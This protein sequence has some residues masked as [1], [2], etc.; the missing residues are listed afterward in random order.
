MSKDILS[1]DLDP[2]PKPRMTHA[3]RWQKRKSVLRFRANRDQ[4]YY[5]AF[6]QGYIP[7][8]KLIMEFD[9]PMPESWSDKKR[10]EHLGKPHQQ[11]PDIDNLVKA[12][13]DSLFEDDKKVHLLLA[14]KR[15]SEKGHITIKNWR[16]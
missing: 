13:L 14:L 10:K 15:W 7:A 2:F 3:D 12:V 11:T 16:E 8:H 4:L 6:A 1:L 5:T 9:L